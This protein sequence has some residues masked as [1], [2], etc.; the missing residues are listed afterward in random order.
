MK[1]D[2]I[3]IPKLRPELHLTATLHLLSAI[4]RQGVS[5]AKIGAMLAHLHRLLEHQQLDASLLE[6]ASRIV[7]D[8][9]GGMPLSASGLAFTTPNV[10][11]I[12]FH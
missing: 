5:E 1:T 7:A 8:W 3:D 11:T 6:A 10:A 4:A 9:Q 12:T 2:P